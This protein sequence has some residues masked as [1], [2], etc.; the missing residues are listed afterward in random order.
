MSWVKVIVAVLAGT[1]VMET[2]LVAG[3]LTPVMLNPMV[4]A[5]AL[6]SVRLGDA[7]PLVK[8]TLIVL[9]KAVRAVPL[10]LPNEPFGA[11][12]YPDTV[13]PLAPVK[14]LSVLPSESLTVKLIALFAPATGPEEPA[15]AAAV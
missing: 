11:A 10:K 5:V 1:G 2:V 14:V 4:W 9:G 15:V 13:T 3:V 8:V 7:T 12:V 6:F